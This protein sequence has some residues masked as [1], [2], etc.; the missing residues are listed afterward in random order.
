MVDV[1]LEPITAP[2]AAPCALPHC[3]IQSLVAH[4]SLVYNLIR[5]EIDARYQGS[6]LG[7][8]W[9][10]FVPVLML[11]VYTF[12][13][14]VIFPAKWP[15][16]AD[17][18]TEFAL[19]LFSG[20]LVFNLFAESVNRAPTLI[21]GNSNFVKRVIFPLDVLSWVSL[22]SALFHAGISFGVLL[23]FSIPVL[24]LPHPEVLLLP[25]A[26]L[27][28]MLLLL[29][30]GWLLSSLGVFLRDVGQIVGPITTALLFLTPIFYPLDTLTGIMH[31]LVALSPLTFAVESVRNAVIWGQDLDWATWFGNLLGAAAFAA[32]A[33]AWFQKTRKGFADVL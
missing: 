17:S 5:R 29:G 19:V 30:V 11:A 28:L 24:G 32:L 21:V 15:R 25:L 12:F 3:A 27:P 31:L 8:A 16:L 10:F 2:Q 14:G 26:L 9:S 33:F 1:E 23:A 13:F 22:G 7:V 18:T 6:L 4:R 20:L